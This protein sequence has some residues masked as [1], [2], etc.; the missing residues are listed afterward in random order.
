MY[1]H[2]IIVHKNDIIYAISKIEMC[3]ILIVFEL[4]LFDQL[5]GIHDLADIET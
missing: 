4:N 3:S 2:C 5:V 1:L